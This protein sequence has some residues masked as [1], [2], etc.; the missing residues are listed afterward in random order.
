MDRKPIL[1][2]PILRRWR[3]LP[4]SLHVENWNGR[5]PGGR[6]EG[7][8]VI[9]SAAMVCNQQGREDIGNLLK[10]KFSGGYDPISLKRDLDSLSLP[11]TSTT[12]GDTSFLKSVNRDH[13]GAL[14]SFTTYRMRP[15]EGHVVYFDRYVKRDGVLTAA[16]VDNNY[17]GQEK[18]IEYNRF[19]RIW[20]QSGGWALTFKMPGGGMVWPQN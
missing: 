7:S 4:K 10:S 15:N 2:R 1:K 19:I 8:C 3:T 14:I 5:G 13:L 16:I 12:S 6:L 20:K 9:A 11:H 17:P 18:Y